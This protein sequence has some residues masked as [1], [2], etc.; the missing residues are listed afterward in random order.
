MT[1]KEYI[2]EF[3][4]ALELQLE[5]KKNEPKKLSLLEIKL[6]GEAG[7]RWLYAI[8]LESAASLEDLELELQIGDKKTKCELVRFSPP[9]QIVVAVPE[10]LSITPGN[11]YLCYKDTLL[12][13]ALIKRC[14][15][16]ADYDRF[17]VPERI[18]NG[19]PAVSCS[20]GQSLPENLNQHQRIAA[21]F[22]F[23]GDCMIWGPPGTGKTQTIA[24]AMDLHTGAGNRSLLLSHA[25][26]AVDGAF[27]RL[28]ETLKDTDVYREGRMIR[29]GACDE[30]L[31]NEFPLISLENVA[32]EKSKVIRD[33]IEVMQ[34][35][36][37]EAQSNRDALNQAVMAVDAVK[38][39]AAESSQA[40]VDL[41]GCEKTLNSL[42]V[43]MEDTKR[44]QAQKKQELE[45][46]KGSWL[47]RVLGKSP[48]QL[49]QE[50]QILENEIQSHM[51]QLSKAEESREK[52]VAYQMHCTAIVCEKKETAAALL[53]KLCISE[54][55]LKACI[56]NTNQKMKDLEEEIK[57]LGDKIDQMKKQILQDAVIVGATLTKAYLSDEL[58][59]KSF[60]CVFVDEV[61]MAPLPQLFLALSLA[62]KQ[63]TLIGDFLQL[64]PIEANIP[65]EKDKEGLA[66]KW[67]DRS[68]FQV[69]GLDS[70]NACLNSP[71]VSPLKTQYRMN[72]AI[73]GVVNEL[74]YGRMLENGENT[75]EKIYPDEWSGASPLVLLDT[76]AAKPSA[77][78]S[79]GTINLYHAVVAAHL[80]VSY[81]LENPDITV[82]VATQYR[83]QAAIIREMVREQSK[84]KGLGMDRVSIN[85]IHSFQGGECDIIIYDSVESQGSAKSPWLLR[86]QNPHIELLL[87]V[88]ITR[89]KSKFILLANKAY[90]HEIFGGK[91]PYRKVLDMV[92]A[93]GSTVDCTTVDPYFKD[94]QDW[95]L[96]K[97]IAEQAEIGHYNEATFWGRFLSDLETAQNRIIIFCPFLSEKRIKTLEQHFQ[98]AISRQ[99]EIILITKEVAD[100]A[101]SYQGTVTKILHKLTQYP[102]TIKLK[103]WMHHK[104]ILIDDDLVWEGSMNILS[105]YYS[106][107]QMAR[108]ENKAVAK[109]ISSCVRLTDLLQSPNAAFSDE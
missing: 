50:V 38:E 16:I 56:E 102:I 45:Q 54:E 21:E 53:D 76:S 81:L 99:V 57:K 5:K 95:M 96:E 104:I 4:K 69:T 27:R 75:K 82:G 41:K 46:V 13:E 1:S 9:H 28:A 87:N 22:S 72:P 64:P 3:L 88:A 24:A 74:F 44:R 98:Q 15:S 29:L 7:T 90:A 71:Y 31:A 47:K 61:S 14:K 51:T 60:D 100:H 93:E 109:D 8:R 63:C 58:W 12:L 83:R 35:S 39:A 26:T 65:K 55:K 62:G 92:E 32:E 79:K 77:I 91:E 17:A 84:A 89:A 42:R 106:G 94:T 107:E 70:V 6:D 101:S 68:I 20:S 37:A 105:T 66:A 52:A 85:T 18:F 49:V 86:K 36:L 59:S 73:A 34:R 33:E 108:V 10:Q 25:N 78:N 67:L 97:V 43:R 11:M 19:N 48:E 2:Q 40:S 23:G 30:T 103:K 80:T